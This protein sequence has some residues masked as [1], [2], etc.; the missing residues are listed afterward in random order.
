MPRK[1]DS[2]QRG[3]KNERTLRDGLGLSKK[4]VLV[5]CRFLGL[6]G[7]GRA[8]ELLLKGLRQLEPAG[9]WVLW[10]P[11][12]VSEYVWSGARWERSFNSPRA[13]VG[14][15]DLLNVPRHDVA[16]YMHQIRPLRA[17]NSITL[18]HDT[19]P[20]RYGGSPASRKLK[21]LFFKAA[22]RASRQIFTVSDFSRSC[23]E[24]DL[25]ISPSR[26][27]VVRYP[28]DTELVDRVAKLRASLNPSSR[29]LYVG[30]FAPHK[31]LERL[32]RAFD[33]TSFRRA[34][35]HLVLVGGD[36]REQQQLRS[37]VGH[38][39]F[40]NVTVGGRCSQGDLDRL[41]ATSTMLVMPSLEEGFGLP[42]WEAKCCALPICVS[43]RGALPEIAQ[44]GTVIFDP[45]S[46]DDITRQIDTVAQST[47]E[48]RPPTSPSVESFAARFLDG[49]SAVA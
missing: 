38:H 36:V 2:K 7:A 34:G 35:G 9:D 13:L 47:E 18:I 14:Q 48:C 16:I 32:I 49:L 21:H 19:I 43:N 44:S 41:Y 20:L 42:A 45:E 24:R 4:R 39:G 29:I 28:C 8:T 33:G 23:L 46:I 27:T 15:K 10:G 17:D 6:G 12:S 1:A 31:N 22:V 40:R 30:R 3:R 5:D 26:I 25:A 37:F 11:D